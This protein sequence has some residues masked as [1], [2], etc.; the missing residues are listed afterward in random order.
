M[1]YCYEAVLCRTVNHFGRQASLKLE[2]NHK[3]INSVILHTKTHQYG[4]Q[5]QSPTF[6]NQSSGAYR[7]KN[8][9]LLSVKH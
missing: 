8:S 4:P 6:Y 9:P 1:V 7:V 2:I 3:L 5:T